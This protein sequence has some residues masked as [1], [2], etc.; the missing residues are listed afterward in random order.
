MQHDHQAVANTNSVTE[1]EKVIKTA[2]DAFRTVHILVNN[3]GILRDKSFTTMTD[4]EW[5][6]VYSVHLKGTYSCTKA[7]WPHFLSQKYGRL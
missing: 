7:A 6:L 2:I 5:D 3:A 4:A 1:G